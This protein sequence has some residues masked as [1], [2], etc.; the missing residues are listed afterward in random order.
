MMDVSLP[1]VGAA[2]DSLVSSGLPAPV[3]DV[4]QVTRRHSSC[5]GRAWSTG[6][7]LVVISQAHGPVR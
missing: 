7:M 5:R 4:V 1:D 3:S 6:D 2:V